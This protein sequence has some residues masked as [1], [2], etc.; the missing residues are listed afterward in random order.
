MRSEKPVDSS[1]IQLEVMRVL[2]SR[3]FER[4]QRSQRFLRYLVEGALADPPVVI[5][6]YAIAIDV[7]DR[8]TS[9]NPSVD[10]TVRVEASRLRS[11]LRE[12]YD[13][14]GRDDLWLIE[15]P[16]GSYSAVFTPRSPAE[17]AS[18][19]IANSEGTIS[20][21]TIERP[22]GEME[23][24]GPPVQSDRS[25]RAWLWIGSILFLV[26][27]A[28]AAVTWR[29]RNSPPNFAAA[30][31]PISLAILPIA[32][33]TGDQN[34]NYVVDG[35][36]DDLIRQ[37]SQLPALRLIGR[38]TVFRYRERAADAATVMKALHVNTIMTGELHRT[39]EHTS[40]AV[41]ITNADGFVVLDRE[42]IADVGDLR[43]V[44][45]DLQRDV[46]AK[47]HVE[48]SALDPGRVLSSVT[49]NPE[50]YQ[51][52]LRSDTLARTMAPADL[53]Q[54]ILHLEKAV[55]LDQHFDLAWASLASE[56][57]FLAIYFEPPREHIP[58][59][60]QYAQRAI[61]INPSMGEAHGSLGLIHLL[62]D[63]DIRAAEVEMRTADAQAAAINTLPCTVHLLQYGGKARAAEEMLSRM[64][65]YDPQSAALTAELS[66][67]NF[68]RGNYDAAIRH[69]HDALQLDPQSP[70]AY[71][72]MGKA[73][74]A[75]GK[76]NEAIRMLRS[77]K[78]RNGFE[79]P[80]LTA[81]IGYALGAS[82]Q[83]KQAL[84]TIRQLSE[85]H[86][87]G[88]IDPYFVSTVYLS[89]NER[90][91]AF[92]WLNKAIDVRSPLAISILSEPKWRP[93]RSD[94]RF[95]QAVQR[96]L[97]QQSRNK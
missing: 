8:N 50:A 86:S 36:T 88:Y 65:T 21:I 2:Q 97:A 77:F 89:I 41:E 34:L 76:H 18:G 71:W 5:K 72:D 58:L 14:E 92:H 78:E 73:L 1:E 33:R 6:E 51:E 31:Q 80:V 62:Y 79:P 45:A 67:V 96:M 35:L 91:A 38:T 19:P 37:L 95:A 53:H 23:R 12:Y 93:F 9:Y 29:Y 16:K 26:V 15:V 55:A 56:H 22:A 83:R 68:Y 43:T 46:L 85:S 81:E 57:L 4:A 63:W 52:F 40:L 94:P 87:A 84:Q 27:A 42:Y 49:S 3:V 25:S 11:R 66:C 24:P 59:A 60:R 74:N 39:A 28:V 90:D 69:S 64:L 75:Q 48:S 82:G 10:A 54:A 30:P 47:L 13:E 44:Q 7:F 70:F 20:G 32:N 17:P 61:Q